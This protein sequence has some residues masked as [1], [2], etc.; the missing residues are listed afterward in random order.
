MVITLCVISVKS[1]VTK[2]YI[3][4]SRQ[5]PFYIVLYNIKG[6][7]SKIN[8]VKKHNSQDIL[9]LAETFLKKLIINLEMYILTTSVLENIARKEKKRGNGMC[10]NSRLKSLDEN[11]INN[12]NDDFERLVVLTQINNNENAIGVVY[13]PNDGIDKT[14]IDTLFY[15]LHCTWKLFTF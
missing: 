14:S 1:M 13:F 4:K 11:L 6:M 3:V 15:E 9:C 2:K 8:E 7:R 10:V 12:K 5:S